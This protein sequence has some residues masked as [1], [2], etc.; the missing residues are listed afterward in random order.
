MTAREGRSS[1]ASK[2]VSSLSFASPSDEFLTCPL[3][4]LVCTTPFVVGSV[5]SG[6]A[7]PR[8]SF[9]GPNTPKSNPAASK[10]LRI[11]FL[12]DVNLSFVNESARAT[13]GRMFAFFES[14]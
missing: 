9:M 2:G 13:I 10:S 3:V 5:P 1:G 14:L 12:M 11:T 4:P 7:V 8:G 6:F